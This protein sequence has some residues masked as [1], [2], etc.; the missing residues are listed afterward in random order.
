M[1][2]PWRPDDLEIRVESKGFVEKRNDLL[3]IVING[4]VLHLRIQLS[5]GH[6]VVGIVLDGKVASAHGLTQHAQAD[7]FFR[8]KEQ[9]EKFSPLGSRELLRNQPGRGIGERGAEAIDLLILCRIVHD[10]G[11]SN[12]TGRIKVKCGF[13]LQRFV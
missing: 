9:L 12:E 3:A 5:L 13:V 10:N 7:S 2:T 11:E 1:G 8:V 6:V 4:E